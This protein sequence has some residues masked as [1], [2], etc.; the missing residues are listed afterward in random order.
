MPPV[1]RG[2]RYQQ[3]VSVTFCKLF[4]YNGYMPKMGK[5]DNISTISTPGILTPPAWDCI[6]RFSP[7]ICVQTSP[8]AAVVGNP[9]PDRLR[10]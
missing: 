1:V 3:Q 8:S 2:L 9:V 10:S 6:P 4:P 5:K 7:V